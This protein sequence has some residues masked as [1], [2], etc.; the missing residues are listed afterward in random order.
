[1]LPTL[2]NPTKTR[3]AKNNDDDDDDNNSQEE[4]DPCSQYAYRSTCCS[5]DRRASSILYGAEGETTYTAGGGSIANNPRQ[6]SKSNPATK[7]ITVPDFPECTSFLV[8]TKAV[9][10]VDLGLHTWMSVT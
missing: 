10:G 6:R 3:R 8:V 2:L 1:M 9:V 7:T 4:L 5:L